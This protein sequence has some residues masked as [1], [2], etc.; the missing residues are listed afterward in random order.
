MKRKTRPREKRG[1][2]AKNTHPS[3]FR[4]SLKSKPKVDQ[5]TKSL[6]RSYESL[7]E[8]AQ[9]LEKLVEIISRGKYQWEATFDA[10]TV[11]VQIVSKDFRIERANTSF[12]SFSGKNITDVVGSHCYEVFAGRK[13]VC[14]GCPL[15]QAVSN[16]SPQMQELSDRVRDR[17]FVA[18]AYPYI[19]EGKKPDAAVMYYHDITEECRLQ[20]EAIQ[21]EKMAA[22]GLLAGGIAHEINNPLGGILA[23]TQL[24]LR[25]KKDNDL[26]FRDLKEIENAAVRCKKIVSDLLDFSRVSKERE[27]C[28]VDINTLLDK[29]FP[30]I[31]G[32]LQALNIKFEFE[33]AKTL[34]QIKGNPDRLQQVFLNILTNACHAMPKGGS[35]TVKTSVEVS[36]NVCI[37][38]SDT[39]VGIPPEDITRIFD[40]FFTTKEP[41]KGT[42][43]GLSI[44]YRIVK[45]H[46]GM[47]RVKSEVGKGSTFTI[48]L[49]AI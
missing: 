28:L 32:D 14:D 31:R 20:Q 15:G 11:P 29:V 1:S 46:G 17:Q 30:F 23:F 21:Q 43:L 24:L 26:L 3:E 25:D 2:S 42:G 35:L 47:I 49:P 10:I 7:K 37:T 8:K 45:E 16:D 19:L 12:A 27:N 6:L 41:L 38:I 4:R 36:R 5:E 18:H 33:R 40:P 22:I 13:K 48:H 39:G 44:A 34:P 9:K